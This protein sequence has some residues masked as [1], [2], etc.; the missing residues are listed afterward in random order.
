MNWNC[1]SM[2]VLVATAAPVAGAAQQAE[3][4]P[5]APPSGIDREENNPAKAASKAREAHQK[6]E[7]R[8]AALDASASALMQRVE[9]A[10]LK[11][12][13]TAK[14]GI[15]VSVDENQVIE[16]R[17]AVPSTAGRVAA[18]RVATAVDGATKIRNLVEVRK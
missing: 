13:A 16:L 15:Q 7:Q 12:P 6:D 5:L 14:L 11:D 9:V 17:G 8:D 3:P 18:E 2:L 4:P 1:L 10:L